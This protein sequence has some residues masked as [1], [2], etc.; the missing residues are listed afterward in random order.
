MN[1]NNVILMQLLDTQYVTEEY[2]SVTGLNEFFGWLSMREAIFTRPLSL[3]A[4]ENAWVQ[5]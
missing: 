5:G 2:Q 1:S 3:H 4:N